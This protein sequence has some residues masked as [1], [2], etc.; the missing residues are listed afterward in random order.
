MAA[1]PVASVRPATDDDVARIAEMAGHAAASL[2]E[3]RG[4]LLLLQRE[5]APPTLDDIV[6]SLRVGDHRTVVGLLDD[7]VVGAV[8]AR[9]EDLDSDRLAIVTMLW[10]DEAARA[11]SVGEALI[12]DVVAWAKTAGC[13]AIDAYALPG[14]R[15]TKNFFEANG[16]KARL[17]TVSQ[18][19]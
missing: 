11:L 18:Q 14:E 16:F 12:G 4:G 8:M 9:I 2:H 1:V 5:S 15:I 3:A 7:S 6:E 17:L 13:S 19:L 10:V